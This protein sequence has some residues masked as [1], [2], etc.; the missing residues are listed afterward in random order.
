MTLHFQFPADG[1]RRQQQ[2]ITNARLSSRGPALGAPWLGFFQGALTFHLTTAIVP[3]TKALAA[4]AVLTE[5][6]LDRVADERGET[7][8]RVLQRLP[9][10]KLEGGTQ[11]P[12]DS[13]PVRNT[14]SLRIG[15][16]GMISRTSPYRS[17][18]MNCASAKPCAERKNS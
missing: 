1:S 4:V 14:G 16:R 10:Q 12:L 7:P 3:S 8:A 6:A 18:R 5:A 15:A 11:K 2:A 9:K 17:R 13:R